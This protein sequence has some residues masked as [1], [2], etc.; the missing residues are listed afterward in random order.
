M[1]KTNSNI[2]CIFNVASHYR[3]PIYKLIDQEL[4]CDFFI[5]DR[6][7]MPLKLMPYNELTGFKKTLKYTPLLGKFYWQKQSVGLAFLN[8]KHYI[9]TGEPFCVSTWFILLITKLLGKKTYLWT[10]GWYGDETPTKKNLKKLFFGLSSKVLLYG[11]YARNMMIKEGFTPEKLICIY[12]S[13]DYDSQIKVRDHLSATA[14]YSNHFKNNYPVLFY[15]GRIQKAKKLEL[16][17]DALNT[18]N[19]K[20]IKCNLIIIGQE[21]DDTSIQKIVSEYKLDK[22][23][24]LYGPCYEENE[25]SELIYNADLCVVPGD[26]GL[27]VM[28]SNVYGTPV[29]THNNFSKHGPEFEAITQ[30]I[31]GD[32]FKEDDLEDLCNKII[33]WTNLSAD[34]REFVRQKCYSILHEKYNP[35]VQINIIKNVL[36]G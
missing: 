11:D 7:E 22:Q 35:H 12:N 24:W 25:I 32:F 20:G 1:P 30:G 21:T 18:L 14:I 34:R 4:K 5:G 19:N 16:L 10:H 23:V 17:I 31:T 8:Y 29:V 13:L 15:I 26:I 6:V 27:T 33:A 28:H 36:N 9:I 3:S 2:C